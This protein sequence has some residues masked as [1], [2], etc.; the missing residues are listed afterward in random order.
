MTLSLRK[1]K[2][3]FMKKRVWQI[4]CAFSLV[5]LAGCAH[6]EDDDIRDVPVTNNPNI[7]PRSG[8]GG[9]MPY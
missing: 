2:V 9:G 1:I 3:N 8:G 6:Y 4:L 7:L 5:L